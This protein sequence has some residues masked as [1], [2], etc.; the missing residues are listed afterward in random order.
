MASTTR[1]TTEHAVVRG[2]LWLIKFSCINI[3]VRPYV[4][5]FSNTVTFSHPA[6][7][8]SY[9]AIFPDSQKND[10]STLPSYTSFQVCQE[11]GQ[12]SLHN[13]LE[14]DFSIATFKQRVFTSG[15]KRLDPA[16]SNKWLIQTSDCRSDKPSKILVS[17]SCRIELVR[18]GA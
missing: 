18:R 4:N 15:V 5:V 13:N 3:Y 1:W 9:A 17:M 10:P 6:L 2:G 14:H 8:L 7:L 16:L 11:C 12:Q